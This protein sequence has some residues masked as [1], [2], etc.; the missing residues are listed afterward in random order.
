LAT[1]LHRLRLTP[2]PC[3][4]N[5]ILSDLAAV[6]ACNEEQPKQLEQGRTARPRGLVAAARQLGAMVQAPDLPESRRHTLRNAPWT[7]P[8]ISS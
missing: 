5:L 8:T 1:P 2:L 4:Q 6:F 7:T 3:K